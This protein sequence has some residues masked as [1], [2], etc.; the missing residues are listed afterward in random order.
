MFPLEQNTQRLYNLQQ[1][2]WVTARI[3]STK[4]LQGGGARL[5]NSLQVLLGLRQQRWRLCG[6]LTSKTP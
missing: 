6:A 5:P 1:L 4:G 3:C 2:Q